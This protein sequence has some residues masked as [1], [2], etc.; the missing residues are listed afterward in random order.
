[1]DFV[2]SIAILPRI[3]YYSDKTNF[4]FLRILLIADALNTLSWHATYLGLPLCLMFV[5]A[6]YL[7]LWFIYWTVWSQYNMQANLSGK[8]ILMANPNMNI[9]VRDSI[10]PQNNSWWFE[11][12]DKGGY[13]HSFPLQYLKL[14]DPAVLL[15][16]QL[17]KLYTAPDA[18]KRLN[19][20]GQLSCGYNIINIL[21]WCHS[22]NAIRIKWQ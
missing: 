15:G 10:W 11:H 16:G 9:K 20:N 22:F 18:L 4:V 14:F 19:Q 1:M 6:Q 12:K 17:T 5:S 3:I 7:F 13:S 8:L 21:N 2:I